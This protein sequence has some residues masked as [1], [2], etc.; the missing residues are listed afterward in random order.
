MKIVHPTLSYMLFSLALLGSAFAQQVQTD[1]DHQANFSQYK[2]Y[3][4]QEIKPPDSLWD[5]RIKTAVGAQLSAKGWTQ[6]NSRGDVASWGG[7]GGGEDSAAAALAG[8]ANL[9]QPNRTTK[10]EPWLSTCSTQEPS[11]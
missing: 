4:W 5:A 11:S 9:T 6:V 3:C 7:G 2:T 1:F 10:M 8:S